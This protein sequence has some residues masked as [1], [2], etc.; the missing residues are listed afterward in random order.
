M[1]ENSAKEKALTDLEDL[2]LEEIKRVTRKGEITSDEWDNLKKAVYIMGECCAMK[3]VMGYSYDGYSGRTYHVPPISYGAHHTEPM[4]D[5]GMSHA[6]GRSPVTGRYVSRGIDHDGY[7]G[8]SIDDRAI[9]S[10]ERLY[11]NA[12]SAH[13]KERLDTM[14]HKIR[15]G[16]M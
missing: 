14:I 10:L 4:Y 2:V 15:N 12:Q 3:D 5:E 16:D 1:A 6:R 8:H 7:S 13:E 9:A 11:D